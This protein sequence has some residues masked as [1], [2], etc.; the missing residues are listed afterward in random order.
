MLS[1]N[2]EL[3]L[4]RALN[5][6]KEYKHEYATLEHLVLA[7]SED[8]EA[9]AALIECDVDIAIL[10]EKLR[11]FLNNELQAIILKSVKESKP[12]AGFQRVIH[13]A[14]IQVHALGQQEIT[15]V[16]VLAEIFSEQDSYAVLF[17]SEQ[18]LTRQDVMNYIS[19]TMLSQVSN[20][21]DIG[22]QSLPYKKQE[23]DS[24]LLAKEETDP[25]AKYCVNLNKL[26]TEQ[27][28]D[29]LI[30]REN[31][32]ERTIEV[33]CRRNKNNPILVGDPGVGKTAIA[34]GLALYLTTNKVPDVLKGSVIYSLDMGALVAGTRYRGDFE[35]RLKQVVKK[36]QDTPSAILFIDEIHTI[37]GAGSTNG[38]A[39][40]AGNLLKPMLARGNFRCIGSTTF[41]EYQNH[42]EKDAALARRFQ[43]IIV[44][45]PSVD[46]AIVMLKGL[47]SFYEKH[48]N[49][50]YSDK[51]IEMAVVLSDRYINDRRLPDKA[52]DVIDEAGA[53]C[54]L[55]L[56][57]QNSTTKIKVTEADIEAIIAKMVHIPVQTIAQDES[58]Q[59]HGLETLLKSKVFGQDRA[60]EELVSIIKLE[61]AG[62]RE[63]E[64]PMGC[65]LFSGP[66]GVGK[67]KLAKELAL[68]LNMELH[69]FDM[70]EYMEK[71]SISRLI[72][73]P[74]GYVGFDQGGLL[75]DEVRKSPYSVVLLDE[76]EKAH[77]D[78]YNIMLQIMD[79]GRVT[80][81]NGVS[82]NFCNTIVIMTTNAGAVSLN[83]NNIGFND[84]KQIVTNS[85]ESN[86]HINRTF[87]PEF[88]NRL[89]AIIEFSPLSSEVIVQI[90]DQYLYNLSTQL[91]EKEINM[92]IND[93]AKEYLCDVG[94]D[95][96]RGAREL[97]R[98]ID[99]KIK[100]TLADEILFGK[101]KKGG[102]VNVDLDN[103]KRELKFGYLESVG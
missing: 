80:D 36:V 3:T 14:A 25:L 56:N 68:A 31:E 94:F 54:K 15:G 32:I 103:D 4:H 6:A 38:S 44:D 95:T 11:Y 52:I 60:I 50:E 48:H 21:P 90:V 53:H 88:R 17:L 93:K 99:K 70:S 45:E 65:Y 33:L 41:K 9:S 78:I 101:L 97:E 72:G 49:V 98:I 19:Q 16:N 86:E 10:C 85:R 2:L 26:A 29:A 100:K 37:I 63:H 23:E 74:P 24:A 76:I 43:K 18:N 89:D 66:T 7:L 42:F 84:L 67:T 12:T 20:A 61:K 87:S 22:L 83:K 1:K 35:E 55:K 77:P 75:T 96:Y 27:K 40:D 73:A 59:I 51:A 34:E 69:R 47:K 58:E 64:K 92:V 102:T 5:S 81:S 46:D 8:P 79:Y 71:H 57:N 82:V 28:I 39:L 30:G 13:R 91:T 62:L